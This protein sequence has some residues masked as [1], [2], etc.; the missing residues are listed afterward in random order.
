M[1]YLD[2]MRYV[3]KPVGTVVATASL[4]ERKKFIT[5]RWLTYHYLGPNSTVQQVYSI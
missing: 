1:E 4:L 3:C 2:S 5:A